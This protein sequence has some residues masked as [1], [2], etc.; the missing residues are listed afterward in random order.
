MKNTIIAFLKNK[1]FF[2]IPACM[3]IV[4]AIAA[5]ECALDIYHRIKDIDGLLVQLYVLFVWTMT[6]LIFLIITIIGYFISK[7]ITKPTGIH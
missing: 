6:L 4:F 7:E 1:A 2:I 3:T 5:S